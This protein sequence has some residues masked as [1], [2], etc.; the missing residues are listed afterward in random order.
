MFEG[1]AELHVQIRAAAAEATD[2]PEKLASIVRSVLRHFAV[3]QGLAGLVDREER[4][5]G[6]AAQR[7]GWWQA[8]RAARGR[9]I[10][11]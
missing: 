5:R 9:A 1:L 10:R 8:V 2:P 7:W 4:K 3:R 6:A 11:W